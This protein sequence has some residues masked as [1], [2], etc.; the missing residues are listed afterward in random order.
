MLYRW[1]SRGTKRLDNLSGTC[2]IDGYSSICS[3]TKSNTSICAYLGKPVRLGQADSKSVSISNLEASQECTYTNSKEWSK[4]I[5][6]SNKSLVIRD[7]G[8]GEFSIMLVSQIYL[9]THSL[10]GD[11]WFLQNLKAAAQDYTEGHKQKLSELV[12]LKTKAWQL[13]Y[14]SASPAVK[15]VAISFTALHCFVSYITLIGSF[16]LPSNRLSTN[17][18]WIMNALSKLYISQSSTS[19]E[20]RPHYSKTTL[21]WFSSW[22][23]YSLSILHYDSTTYLHASNIGTLHT[24][25]FLFPMCP[26]LLSF[27]F[28]HIWLRIQAQII[29]N[30]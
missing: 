24:H 1:E 10:M 7:R 14:F 20:Y 26:C 9:K 28:L 19:D 3:S 30:N 18:Y 11:G 4:H 8:Q 6:S 15:V 17:I 5:W 27:L 12:Y 23:T 13:Q 16:Y 21:S 25:E 29:H 22:M 2:G